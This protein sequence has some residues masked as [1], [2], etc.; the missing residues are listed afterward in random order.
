M[1]TPMRKILLL[2]L[3]SLGCLH[4]FTQEYLGY[5][6]GNYTGVNG[7][8]SN[9]ANIADSKYFFDVNLLSVSTYGANDKA[10]YKLKNFSETFKSENL[11]EKLFGENLGPASG[12]FSLD[13]RGPSGMLSVNNKT[14][15]AFS[16][17]ARMFANVV[18]FDSKLFDQLT[19]SFAKDPALPYTINSANDMRFSINGWSEYGAS[20]ARVLMDKG[21]HA[22]KAGLTVKYLAG[23]V[24]GFINVN[25]FRG[26]IDADNILELPYLENVSGSAAIGFSGVRVSGFEAKELLKQKGYGFGTDLGF[27][28]EFRPDAEMQTTDGIHLENNYKKLYKFKIGISVL[29]LGTI[30]YKRDPLR[31]GDYTMDISNGERLYLDEFDNVDFDDYNKFFADRPE[32]FIRNNNIV[33]EEYNV[34]LPA[35][36]QVDADYLINDGFYLALGGQVSLSNNNSKFFNNRTYSGVTLTPRYE[37]KLLGLYLPVNYNSLTGMNVGLSFRIGPLF[38]GSGSLLTA[39]FGSSKQAD[40]HFGLRIGELK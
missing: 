36:L 11:R 4:S 16:T 30:L 35:T 26:T 8:F 3:A 13:L 29:D 10:S 23:A 6:T 14:A 2:S 18:D 5:R 7:V 9:P 15:V 20:F 27:V 37:D 34:S 22:I 1:E 19:N 31:S 40:V 25:K 33:D 39:L 28:Y 38:F 12:M 21:A 17:R 24:N 32:Y